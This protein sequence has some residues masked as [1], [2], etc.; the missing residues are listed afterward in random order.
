MLFANFFKFILENRLLE[1][2]RLKMNTYPNYCDKFYYYFILKV[3]SK[4]P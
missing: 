3:V 4:L 1:K 2:I